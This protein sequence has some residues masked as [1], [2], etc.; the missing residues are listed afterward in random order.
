M[1]KVQTLLKKRGK[2]KRKTEDLDCID[3]V[4]VG[5]ILFVVLGSIIV[6]HLPL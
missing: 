5:I 6:H 3:K 2:I 4:C 1:T